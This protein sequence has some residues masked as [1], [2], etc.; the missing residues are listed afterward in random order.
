MKLREL[1]Q[2]NGAKGFVFADTGNGSSFGE[3]GRFTE[4]S[5]FTDSQ[6]GD[7]ELQ[8]LSA[9]VQS[10][11]GISCNHASDWVVLEQGSDPYRYK[12]LL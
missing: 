12:I 10:D 8:Q 4:W 1:I 3:K 7:I 11:D 5:E 2:K 6:Y 9:P